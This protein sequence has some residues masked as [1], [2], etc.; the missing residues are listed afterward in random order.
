[1]NA[2]DPPVS[3]LIFLLHP[4]GR[5]HM[6][7]RVEKLRAAHKSDAVTPPPTTVV[8][9]AEYIAALGMDKETFDAE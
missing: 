5:P 1:M 7:Q 2:V 9:E 6:H 8:N 3:L 4:R